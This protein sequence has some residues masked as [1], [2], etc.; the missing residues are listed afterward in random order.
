MRAQHAERVVVG[1]LAAVGHRTKP[2]VVLRQ[3]QAAGA[4]ADHRL[5]QLLLLLLLQ[6]ERR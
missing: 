5:L 4:G 2:T 6:R 3:S 1:C